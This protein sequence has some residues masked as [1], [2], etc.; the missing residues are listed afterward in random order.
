MLSLISSQAR[1]SSA[2]GLQHWTWRLHCRFAGTG[3][4]H[5]LDLTEDPTWHLLDLLHLSLHLCILSSG[6]A[7]LLARQRS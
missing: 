1:L 5:V 3:H 4:Q 7:S 6:V 2:R